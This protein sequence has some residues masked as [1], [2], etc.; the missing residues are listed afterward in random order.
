M[1]EELAAYLAERDVLVQQELREHESNVQ[2]EL[3]RHKAALAQVESTFQRRVAGM[4][5]EVVK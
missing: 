4:S 1:N 3:R 2:S 5:Q